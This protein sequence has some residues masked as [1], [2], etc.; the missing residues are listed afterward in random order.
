MVRVKTPDTSV[1]VCNALLIAKTRLLRSDS[2]V[3]QLRIAFAQFASGRGGRPLASITLE[4]LEAWSGE[5]MGAARTRKG[6]IQYVKLLFGWAQRRGWITANPAAAL[7]FPTGSEEPPEIHGVDQV[8]AILEEARRQEPGLARALAIRY[9]AGLRTAEL[10][11]IGPENIGARFIEVPAAKSKTRQRRL[12]TIQPNLAAWLAL[13]ATMPGDQEK[14]IARV[15]GALGLAWPHNVTRHSFCS[16]HLAQFQSAAK[17][18]LEA[19]HSEAMLFA[20]YRELV[21]P[22]DAAAFWA[23]RP[24]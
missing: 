24:K 18:A 22:E 5:F 20:H 16:Y 1:E 3:E 8:K 2:Y 9:F 23:L 4:E 12:V 17:T 6:R 10:G 14:R 7:E 21:T 11:R 19:G 13:S 15:Y